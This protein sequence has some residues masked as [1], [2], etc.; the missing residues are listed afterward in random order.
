M[1]KKN[2]NKKI[3]G[4]VALCLSIAVVVVLSAVGIT[5]AFDPTR[6][7]SFGDVQEVNINLPEGASADGMIGGTTSDNM[8]IGGN[9]AVTGTS[10]FTG[11][12]VFGKTIQ[13]GGVYAGTTTPAASFTLVAADLCDNSYIGVTPSKAVINMTLPATTTLFADC[14]TTNGDFIDVVIGNNS[15]TAATTTTIVAG[16][17]IDLQEPDGQNVVIGGLNYA[18]VRIMRISSTEAVAIIDETIPAD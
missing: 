13:G 17:G 8:N 15:A 10:A 4:V 1:T 11:E 5:R 14:L 3:V 7:I 9:L 2:Q 12:A 6:P 18:Q 16:A